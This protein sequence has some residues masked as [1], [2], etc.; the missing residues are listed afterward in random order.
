MKIKNA[1][2]NVSLFL[3]RSANN[4]KPCSKNTALAVS[5]FI[6]LTTL[7]VVHL[8]FTLW[9]KLRKIPRL[10]QKRLIFLLIFFANKDS[11][12]YNFFKN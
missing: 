3:I 11:L 8:F 4:P 6:G 10:T 9:M 1:L 2:D 7:G 12:L 5:I